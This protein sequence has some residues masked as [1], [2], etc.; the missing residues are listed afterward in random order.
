MEILTINC[1][2]EVRKNLRCHMAY[3]YGV[4]AALTLETVLQLPTL[5]PYY[6]QVQVSEGN[7]HGDMD[8]PGSHWSAK[9]L[10]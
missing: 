6:K 8:F 2:K 4:I 7:F 3:L 1:T 10:L 5:D 9:H